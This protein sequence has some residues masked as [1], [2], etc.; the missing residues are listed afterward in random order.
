MQLVLRRFSM[1]ESRP[2]R[3][4]AVGKPR[5]TS[6]APATVGRNPTQ[7]SGSVPNA[8]RFKN[9]PD[10]QKRV[11]SAYLHG[12]KGGGFAKCKAGWSIHTRNTKDDIAVRSGVMRAHTYGLHGPFLG[13]YGGNPLQVIAFIFTEL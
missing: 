8:H 6:K 3:T 1:Q 12:Y 13:G 5:C 2:E 4:P 9:P 7:R 11:L 10:T